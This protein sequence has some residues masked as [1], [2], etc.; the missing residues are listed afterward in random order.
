MVGVPL[1]NHTFINSVINVYTCFSNHRRPYQDRHRARQQRIRRRLVPGTSGDH[2][3]GNQQA[4]DIPVWPV[5]GQ[6][7][8]GWAA[9]EGIVCQGISWKWGE[10]LWISMRASK[11]GGYAQRTNCMQKNESEVMVVLDLSCNILWWIAKGMGSSKRGR[12]WG[13]WGKAKAMIGFPNACSTT[14][15]NCI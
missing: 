15:S 6:G 12:G 5:A 1:L 7:Q 14:G 9:Q 3:S 2:E 13:F 10:V 8:R 11:N 4:M